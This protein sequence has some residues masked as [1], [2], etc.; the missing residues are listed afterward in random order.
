MG[1][2]SQLS[3]AIRVRGTLP[4]YS[5]REPG[6]HPMFYSWLPQHLQQGKFC[7]TMEIKHLQIKDTAQDKMHK[8]QKQWV[9]TRHCRQKLSRAAGLRTERTRKNLQPRQKFCCPWNSY[10]YV[11]AAEKQLF[12]CFALW[13]AQLPVLQETQSANS[14]WI[15]VSLLEEW[16]WRS[17]SPPHSAAAAPGPSSSPDHY[18]QLE[19]LSGC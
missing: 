3:E 1:S 4:A 15:S 18:P 14:K 11:W 9:F 13:E 12:I 8:L 10:S 5:A 6:Q 17:P 2:N 7:N 16:H 19:H